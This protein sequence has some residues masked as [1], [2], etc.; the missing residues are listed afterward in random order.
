MHTHIC[1]VFH[2]Y[3]KLN[4]LLGLAKEPFN[5]AHFNFLNK[6]CWVFQFKFDISSLGKFGDMHKRREKKKIIQILM[7]KA[8]YFLI[9]C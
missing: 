1:T 8:E 6:V 7:F 3:N 5:H 4:R 2:V 9:F